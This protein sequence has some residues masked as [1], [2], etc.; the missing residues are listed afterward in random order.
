MSDGINTDGPAL[1]EAATTARRK[2]VPLFCVGLGDN[3]PVRDLKLSDLMVEDVV[4]LNDIVYFEAKLTASGFAGR[5]VRVV[6]RQKDKPEILAEEKL[7]VAPEG[8]SQ[9]I[10]LAHRPTEE[11]E[12]A[13]VVEVEP[14]EGELETGNNRQERIV[15][16]RKEQ[17]R[18]LLVQAY[19]NYEFRYLRNMLHRDDDRVERRAPGCRSGTCRARRGHAARFSDAPG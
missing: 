17:I 18:V 12:F 14:L 10:R 19:P 16:V 5:E 2:G 15:R 4:F 6:L 8:Q 13:Y 1:A 3:R 7:K 9:P 11:G